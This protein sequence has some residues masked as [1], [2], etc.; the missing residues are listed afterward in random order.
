V[1]EFRCFL[2]FIVPTIDPREDRYDSAK[3][4]DLLDAR[5]R[6]KETEIDR[7]YNE[8]HTT[9]TRLLLS[10]RF[11]EIAVSSLQSVTSMCQ[12]I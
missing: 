1:R 7:G 8:I 3:Y 9:L 6:K 2:Q 4:G 12:C 11:T 10:F 5:K